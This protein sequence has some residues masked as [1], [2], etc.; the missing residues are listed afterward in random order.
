MRSIAASHITQLES[1][2]QPVVDNGSEG[3]TMV[4]SHNRDESTGKDSNIKHVL[5]T[6]ATG[7]LGA[8]IVDALLENGYKV[9][10]GTR[11]LGRGQPLLDARP[12]ARDDG[13]LDAVRIG[14]FVGGE[15]EKSDFGMREAAKGVD[16]I[17]H[18]ASVGGGFLNLSRDGEVLSDCDT[19]QPFIENV[20][21]NERDLVLPAVNGV[22][23]VLFAAAQEASIKRVVI[24]SSVAALMDLSR[25][26]SY[27]YTAS[28]WNPMSYAEAVDPK[29]DVFASHRG[30]KKFAE[31]AA[32]DF[33]NEHR[34][35]PEF[36]LVT[37]CPP[38]IYGPMV[39]PRR[40]EGV[41]S[42]NSSNG[43][44]WRF[45][46]GE[47]NVPLGPGV[48]F[49]VDV[50]DLA[51]AHFRALE[52]GRLGERRFI[53]ASQEKARYEAAG[54]MIRGSQL[55]GLGDP[56]NRGH[57]DIGNNSGDVEV[58]V[59]GWTT[60]KELGITCRDFRQCVGDLI[61]QVI[62]PSE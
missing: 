62:R 21:N 41:Q 54:D 30:S 40:S 4:E 44:L 15:G 12:K 29:T 33:M 6:G 57:T 2:E 59:D 20:T 19:L 9:R 47:M 55:P 43:L 31:L 32:W 45:A 46:T 18:V 22:K 53:I 49:W 1:I 8:H 34:P 50:R 56:H 27:T 16:A 60:E 35:K 11:S 26:G 14:D 23:A 28:D 58:G 7:F 51:N 37:L 48:T 13:T 36:E 38:L 17:V 3:N 5:V 52:Q 10:A 25:Q 24:T 39:H 61:R 42:L